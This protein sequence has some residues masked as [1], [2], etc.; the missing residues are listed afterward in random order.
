MGQETRNASRFVTEDEIEALGD[1]G[2][3]I[4]TLDEDILITGK[5]SRGTLYGV[6]EFL[7]RFVGFMNLPISLWKM[8]SSTN[9]YRRMLCRQQNQRVYTLVRRQ[10]LKLRYDGQWHNREL[11][12]PCS[13]TNRLG[14]L[15]NCY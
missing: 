11:I 10:A 15:I 3:I 6:Y 1:D 4:K 5:T 9:Y 7:R 12:S 13:S 2:F 8:K 14:D